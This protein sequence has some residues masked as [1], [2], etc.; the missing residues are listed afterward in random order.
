VKVSGFTNQPST[1]PAVSPPSKP[2]RSTTSK[3]RLNKSRGRQAT[4]T[5]LVTAEIS[6]GIAKDYECQCGP[7][8]SF[9][10]GAAK[11]VVRRGDGAAGTAPHVAHQ[12]GT[13]LPESRLEIVPDGAVA[14]VF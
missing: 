1:I 12:F 6:A 3:V 5:S 14:P 11:P 2:K 7:A 9:Q 8:V 13:M 4:L 10:E